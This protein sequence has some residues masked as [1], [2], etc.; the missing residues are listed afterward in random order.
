[1]LAE[2]NRSTWGLSP[3]LVSGGTRSPA[4]DRLP[5]PVQAR[6]DAM[7]ISRVP[8]VDLVHEAAAQRQAALKETDVTKRKEGL[9]VMRESMDDLS[10]ESA[11]RAILR[12]LYSPDQMREQ[13]T[14]FWFNQFNIYA[15][16]SG[17]RTMIADYEDTVRNHALGK[18]RDLLEAT[19]RHPAMLRYLDNEQNVAGHINENYAR[20]I[21]ELHSM[22]VGSGYSQKDVQELAR[23]LTGVGLRIPADNPKLRSNLQPLYIRDGLFEFNPAR[24][25]FGSKQF[26]G[27][28]IPGTGFDE[29]EKALDLIA[30]S[31]ATARHIS[32]RIAMYFLADDPPPALVDK[33]VA[34]WQSSR[35]D[36]PTILKSMQAAP[37]YKA[38]LGHAF[39]DPRH[40]VISALRHAYGD[41]VIVNTDPILAWLDRMSESPYG[42]LTPDGYPLDGKS[43]SG[44]GQM[45]VRLE[46]AR[47]IGVN[48]TGLFTPRGDKAEKRIPA[49]SMRNAV[50]AAGFD[51]LVSPQT[52]A[53]LAKA[54]NQ[55][56]WNILFLASPEFMQR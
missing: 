25:D 21:M 9:R 40:Y 7:R 37:E 18:Y 44:P 56:E 2:L 27:Q 15:R 11:T 23:I 1:M 47:A 5:A 34:A 54:R 29:V 19:L 32:T 13:M 31:P 48:A 6:I 33:M 49:P 45:T 4:D 10:R 26:L 53:V 30:A 12:D 3:Q 14:W 39:K 35:G 16:K 43:W 41:T 36:I 42:R 38:S 50:W 17:L 8:M 46:I 55:Q 52:Q 22:G 51:K 24:H 28:T 20:E